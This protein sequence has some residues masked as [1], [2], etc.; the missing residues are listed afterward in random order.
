MNT[1]SEIH[2]GCWSQA[3]V[4][5]NGSFPPDVESIVEGGFLPGLWQSRKELNSFF[6]CV[7]CNDFL[8]IEVIIVF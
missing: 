8:H 7:S 6:L 3:A 1:L 2:I 4:G 5:A